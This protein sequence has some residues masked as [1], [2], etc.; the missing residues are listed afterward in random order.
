M[1]NNNNVFEKIISL[2]NMII[3][4]RTKHINTEGTEKLNMFVSSLKSVGLIEGMALNGSKGRY[5]LIDGASWDNAC[6]RLGESIAPSF[7]AWEESKF[8]EFLK[9][10]F[11]GIEKTKTGKKMT[12]RVHHQISRRL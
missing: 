2:H 8:F 11:M 1:S 7:V 4:Q 10:R 3:S 6:H 12:G 5:F 9:S